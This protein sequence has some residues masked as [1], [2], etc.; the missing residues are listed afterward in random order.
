MNNK[1]TL[2]SYNSRLNTNNITLDNIMETIDTLPEAKEVVLQDKS[3]EITENG[4]TTIT[5][6]SGYDGLNNVE[7]ITNVASSGG[8]ETP[9]I[10]FII[11]EYDTKG[12]AKKIT[13]V[14][15]TA[16][17]YS[18]FASPDSI[19]SG[20]YCSSLISSCEEIIL[21]QEITGIPE[22]C[23]YN[24]RYLKKIPTTLRRI[25]GRSFYYCASLTHALLPNITYL[26][27]KYLAEGCFARCVSLKAVWL[28]SSIT[29][30]NFE[31]GV[32]SN[33]SSLKK[34]FIDLPRATVETFGGYSKKWSFGT[35]ASS[36][37]VICNDD[38]GFMTKEEFDAID[39]ATYSM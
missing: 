30:S 11:N 8:G 33:C 3:V 28:G 27:G 6:D 26:G 13:V 2:Q 18:A 15:M 4:T 31:N 10:G 35:V 12:F 5:A 20:A 34:I 19:T 32:F 24:N 36:C 29:S 14:G 16:L 39:W 37:Q 25:E 7:V 38:E 23:F 17:P 22:D 9:Q 21:P 1:E